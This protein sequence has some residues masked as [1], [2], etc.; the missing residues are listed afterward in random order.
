MSINTDPY[1]H[2]HIIC[3][4]ILV[5]KNGQYLV[6]RRSTKKR[7]APGVV[8]PIGGKVDPGENPYTTAM[9]ELAEEAN[10]TVSNVRLEAV[11]VEIEPVKDEPY[12]WLVFYFSGDYAGGEITQTEEGELILLSK[13]ELLAEQLFPSFREVVERVLNPDDGT[14]CATFT[15]D[16]SKTKIVQRKMDICSI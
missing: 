3:A 6:I 11:I 13:E 7:Y 9:R 15:Y 4:N 16:E 12:N 5:R 2:Q 10:I 14:I 8:S 1:I